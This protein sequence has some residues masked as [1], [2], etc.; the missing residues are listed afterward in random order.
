MG[1]HRSGDGGEAA[2]VAEVDGDRV[3]ALGGDHLAAHE[4]RGDRLGHHQVQQV[5]GLLLLRL[6]LLRALRH[7]QLE[8]VRV[9]LHSRQHVVHDV[10][11]AAAASAS[12][13]HDMYIC[14]L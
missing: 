12:A 13:S 10:R 3:E 5:L 6:V 4:H 1:A 8:V 9:L 2:D 11:V 7:L 14:T